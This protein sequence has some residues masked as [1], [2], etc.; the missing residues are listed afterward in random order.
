MKVEGVLFVMHACIIFCV[1]MAH[2]GGRVTGKPR[3]KKKQQSQTAS[4]A[5][6]RKKLAEIQSNKEACATSSRASNEALV[7]VSST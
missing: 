1:K 3:G 5:R 6:K 7:V 2:G 4:P